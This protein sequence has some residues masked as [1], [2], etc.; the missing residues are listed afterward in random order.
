MMF[1]NRIRFISTI[2]LLGFV[3]VSQ[4]FARPNINTSGTE[5][6]QVQ[7]KTTA[8]CQ[9]ATAAIDLDINNVDARM[10]TGGDMWWNQ[11]LQVA[12]YEIPKGSGKSSQFAASCWIGGFDAQGQLKVAAQEYRQDGN[13][14]WPGALDANNDID[15]V[16]CL[17]WDY[18]WKVNKSDI[19][20]FIDLH[21]NGQQTTSATYD[22]INH[23]PASGNTLGV[24]GNN[25]AV[26][27]LV[28]GHTY[29]PFVDLNNDGIYDPN[30]TLGGG[31]D[32]PDITGDQYIWWVFNDKGNVKL[33]SQT[34]AI[35]LEV[36]T[37]AFA[38]SSQDFLN[39]ATFIKYRVI[40]RG[41]L[42]MD[43]TYIAVWDDCDLGYAFDDYIGCD[44]TRGLGIDYNGSSTDGTG[45]VNSY[46][47]QVPQ[48]GLDLFQGPIRI[49]HD[50]VTGKDR[51]SILKMTNFTYFNNDQSSIGN[52]VNGIE[53][54]GYM[55]G[56]IRNGSHFTDDFIGYG[57][58]SK[59]YGSGP[60]TH[61]VFS[62]D[63]SQHNQWSECS[64]QNPPG[65]RR[66]IFS[67]GPFVLKPGASN[68]I[69]FGCVWVPNVGGCPNTSFSSIE[70]VDDQAQ[71]LFDNNFKAIEGPNAPRL[72]IRNLDRRLVL[73][74]VNDQGSNNY[75]EQFGYVDSTLYMQAS[76]K[77]HNLGKTDSLYQFQGYRVFQ[78]V[79]STQI[80]QIFNADGS[81]NSA[82]AAEVFQCDKKDGVSTIVNWAKNTAISDSTWIPSIMVSGKDSGIVHSFEINQDAFATG[83]D[84]R[85]VNYKSYYFY[86]IAYAYLDWRSNATPKGFI[87]TLK[88]SDTTQDVPYLASSHGANS[89][90]IE[91]G[92]GMPNPANGNMGTVLNSDYG[93]GVIITT[94]AGTGNG[95]NVT[96]LSAASEDS[97][98]RYN[99]VKKPVYKQ[100]QGPINVKVIDP[101]MVAPMNWELK[102]NGPISPFAAD[103]GDS[104]SKS[105]W[106]L[107]GTDPTGALSPVTITSE[108][109]LNVVNEQI[110]EDYGISL[111][112]QQ[113]QRPGDNPTAGN[114]YI[115][116]DI[117]FSD[118]TK[119][120][121]GGVQDASDSN[122]LNWLRS[123]S[124]TAV[125]TG[126]NP[127]SF[128]D[129]TQDPMASYANLL[130]NSAF[131]KAT[132]GP[133]ALVAPFTHIGIGSACGFALSPSS[134]AQPTLIDLPSIDLVFTPDMTKWTRC[135]VIEMQEDPAL[136]QGG[137][138]KFFVRVHPS[139]ASTD[140][141]HSGTPPIDPNGNPLFVTG[142]LDG[143]G[144]PI[145]T[146]TS[147]GMSW[148]PGYAINPETGDRLNIVFSEDS[149][150]TS[151][152]GADMLWN[153]TSRVTSSV[154]GADVSVIFGGK[155]FIYVLNS[156]YD[157]DKVFK[158][159]ITSSLTT[160]NNTAW[161]MAQWAGIP[162][163]NATNN[164][165]YLPLSQGFI[166]TE[167]RLRFRVTRPYAF[168]N[169]N[170]YV[171][172]IN[173]GSN[174]EYFPTLPAADSAG[175]PN[176]GFPDYTFSTV[177]LAATQVTDKTDKSSI[178]N[179]IFA[180]PN[181][182][183]GYSGYETNRYDTKVRIINL[184]A[185]VT[186]HIYSL[187]G[188]L[189]RTLTKSDPSVPFID[190]DIR[191]SV[192]LPVA[193]GMY[194]M[195]VSLP[196]IGETILKWF[197]G[198]RPID[199]TTY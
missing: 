149:W 94:E 87:A 112:M 178:L 136:A 170:R 6:R 45:Q 48:V 110:L 27:T 2:T 194:L 13:D 93:T 4:V 62:G 10:L 89:T 135:V 134:A 144:K 132:W 51:D 181:P 18:F 152:N 176:S 17:D 90:S 177:N 26:L 195:H 83:S 169:S 103:L 141:V 42:E 139:W 58:Q 143:S 78:L 101:V 24:K 65:D 76:P 108:Q 59:G 190:W 21:K 183:Y 79:D 15:A 155:H 32:Y 53:I 29:A 164:I 123:G 99:S 158:Q 86:A 22:A 184:P 154:T 129:N 61:F 156:T 64:S 122:A 116:S 189:I 88:G 105:T 44:T 81:V 54:Y 160:D 43:S 107:L 3:G 118:S 182:Y 153:P 125:T 127:C 148:F 16:G 100:G 37:S 109:Y 20:T 111:T 172:Y 49:I 106:Q 25:N 68:D 192:G 57:I 161:R 47:T 117:T 69:I 193:S 166:P 39:N 31:F 187:D 150:L 92:V 82:V 50:P 175:L 77:A 197:G 138:D 180:V 179:R 199:I 30:N 151:D 191:N 9:P 104:A 60:Q 188:T 196:G 5:H 35:G 147:W 165:Q 23:W 33:Q 167:T 137:A 146:D 28:P 63:P 80:S 124:N 7:L 130:S 171:P 75:K 14:Y 19:Q 52:P 74:L 198:M 95:G 114:G 174:P 102:I 133:Y 36:Q 159:K 113:V 84:K 34:Q 85:L 119:P 72:V 73:Y 142:A 70:A 115:S 67:S 40:N 41:N 91:I 168:F 186:I 120:W 71:A 157:S 96:A 46:G 162:L 8:G 1:Q 11:G 145:I 55:T 126:I 97:A 185:Q 140:G 12:A 38:Y 128:N 56:T 163:L 173:R 98:V 121:L 66:M 131:N